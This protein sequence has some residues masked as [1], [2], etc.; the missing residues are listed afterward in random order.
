MVIS[1][2]LNNNKTWKRWPLWLDTMS[3]KSSLRSPESRAE[4][5]LSAWACYREKGKARAMAQG[6]ERMLATRTCISSFPFLFLTFTLWVPAPLFSCPTSPLDPGS[7]LEELSELESHAST[8]SHSQRGFP[9]WHF[10]GTMNCQESW[11]RILQFCM[12]LSQSELQVTRQ[13]DYLY[14]PF[15]NLR[16][17]IL[18]SGVLLFPSFSSPRSLWYRSLSP[19]LSFLLHSTPIWSAPFL[20]QLAP[21]QT[22]VE[23]HFWPSLLAVVG[24][25]AGSGGL[26]E[27]M[28][29]T[30]Y[31]RVLWALPM[32]RKCHREYWPQIGIPRRGSKLGEWNCAAAVMRTPWRPLFF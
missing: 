16:S 31:P 6:R 7:L 28:A 27:K 11:F 30:I 4:L 26:W 9:I 12:P 10:Q 21:A 3:E 15:C 20:S 13:W 18:T 8:F 19:Q 32:S 5:V 17:E 22:G 14:G 1:A 24:L 29:A 23:G 2:L 25:S